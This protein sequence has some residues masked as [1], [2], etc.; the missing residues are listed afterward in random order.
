MLVLVLVLVWNCGR[1]S[2]WSGGKILMAAH[3][4]LDVD[5][6]AFDLDIGLKC[7]DGMKSI[8]ATVDSK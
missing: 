6:L 5:A 2:E 3:P 8:V 1:C 7:T 4:T